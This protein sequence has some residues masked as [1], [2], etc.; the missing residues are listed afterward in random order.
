MSFLQDVIAERSRQIECEKFST[1]R[2]DAIHTGGQLAEAAAAYALSH[3]IND[4]N[5]DK[6]FRF[7][8][9][10]FWARGGYEFTNVDIPIS[11]I[12][13]LS[14]N[15]AWF[16]PG[17]RRRDLVKAAAL[18]LAEGERLDRMRIHNQVEL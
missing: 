18:L 16:K 12:F 4:N 6:I 13:P 7:V 8:H 17:D 9:E 3:R 2:D 11:A 1:D 10:I 5:G 15:I 14:W